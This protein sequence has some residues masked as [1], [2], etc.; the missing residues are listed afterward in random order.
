MTTRDPVDLERL[1]AALAAAPADPG[2]TTPVGP[3]D[4]RIFDAVHGELSD[5]ERQAIVD[6]LWRDPDAAEAW[7][8]ARELEPPVPASTRVTTMEGSGAPWRWLG[9]A[10]GIVLAVG[11]AWQLA[12]WRTTEA[13][14]YRSGDGRGIASLLPEDTPLSRT[15]PTLRWTPIDGA[16]Y[17][18]RVLTADLQPLAEAERLTVAEYTLPADVVAGVPANTPLLWQV[19]AVR[20]GAAPLVSPT[21]SVRLQ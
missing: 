14:V 17:R 5:T 21:F 18:V 13:P 19:E 11:V 4:G 16:Q 3:D 8:L 1:R 7:R 2:A 20:T 15:A 6:Q 9:L 12:P 10:A